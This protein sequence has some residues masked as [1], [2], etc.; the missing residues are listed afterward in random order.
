MREQRQHS[1]GSGDQNVGN[2]KQ[3]HAIALDVVEQYEGAL[4]YL[5]PEEFA[6]WVSDRRKCPTISWINY[7]DGDFKSECEVQQ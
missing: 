6:Q 3:A 5:T 4:E 7:L 2:S 1:N